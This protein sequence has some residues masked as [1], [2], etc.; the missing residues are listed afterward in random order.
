MVLTIASPDLTAVRDQFPALQPRRGQPAPIFLDTPGGTQVPEPVLAAVRDCLVSANANTGGAFAT[1][2]RSDAILAGARDAVADLLN[3][4]PEEI[5]FGANMTT[6]TFALSRAIATLLHPGDEIVTT[7]LDH[8]A[9]IAP[10]LA[11]ARERGCTV[12]T[13][14]ITIPDCRLDMDQLGAML[15]PKTRLL[16]I[17]YASNAT[18][19]INDIA[20]ATRWAREVGAWTYVDAV[21]F[22]PHGSVD[23]QAIGCDFLACSAY[24][25]YG[26]HVGVLYGTAERLAEIPAFKVRPQRDEAPWRHETGTL[27]HEGIAG[28]GAAVDY[29]AD[30]GRRF[31]GAGPDAGR[32]AA[33]VAAM[34]AIRRHEMS[35]FARLLAGVE[36][37]PGV[38][39]WGITDR[40]AF[41][42]RGPTLCFS[43]DARSPRGT[44]AW[45]GRHGINAWDGDYYATALMERLGLAPDGAVRLGLA[46]YTTTA[47]VDRV[48]DVLEAAAR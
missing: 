23:V 17:G 3:A 21:Q 15:S 22:A 25:F 5:V 16:A 31:G 38:R 28:T 36:R 24:K 46:H 7:V 6:L 48:L 20:A 11:I 29:L 45:L 26:P 14:D 34:G 1:S 39:V 12:R 33:L 10:W 19:T 41:D 47:E 18:G 2:E 4:A 8:D 44:A 42:H 13:V 27:N 30:L 43:W 40:A 32:R 9:N 35:L 37:L